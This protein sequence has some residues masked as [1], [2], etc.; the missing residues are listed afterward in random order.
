VVIK[1]CGGEAQTN[2]VFF[3]A[4]SAEYSPRVDSPPPP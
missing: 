3:H 2:D 1:G 4:A